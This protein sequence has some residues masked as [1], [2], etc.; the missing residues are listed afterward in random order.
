[1]T[2]NPQA[3]S[4]FIKN[5]I[6]HAEI[7]LMR[8]VLTSYTIGVALTHSEEVYRIQGICFTDS[9]IAHKTVDIAI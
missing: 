6:D 4:A 8:N 1:M 2:L 5:T 9:I 3:F 7:G